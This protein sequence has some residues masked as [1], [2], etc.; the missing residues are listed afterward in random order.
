MYATMHHRIAFGVVDLSVS[1][2]P[3][4][5]GEQLP[6][7][8]AIG[9]NVWWGSEF[10]CGGPVLLW[11]AFGNWDLGRLSEFPMDLQQVISVCS[12]QINSAWHN[13]A[14]PN[15]PIGQGSIARFKEHDCEGYEQI[16]HAHDGRAKDP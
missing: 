11:L 3:P 10:W 13:S 5:V 1:S 9:P 16:A 2:I 12:G 4:D 14:A 6:I 7:S 15:S 8:Q